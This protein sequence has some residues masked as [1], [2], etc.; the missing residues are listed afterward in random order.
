MLKQCIS[1]RNARISPL[2][3]RFVGMCIDRTLDSSNA[4]SRMLLLPT[5]LFVATAFC[6]P[7][8]ARPH[9][10]GCQR[11]GSFFAMQEIANRVWACTQARAAHFSRQL[12][13][14]VAPLSFWNAHSTRRLA[15][16]TAHLCPWM[17]DCAKP[18]ATC[19]FEVPSSSLVLKQETYFLRN[20]EIYYRGQYKP[21]RSFMLFWHICKFQKEL[22]S[23]LG[24]QCNVK[25]RSHSSGY[26]T[27]LRN[28]RA[29]GEPPTQKKIADTEKRL[30]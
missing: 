27:K 25:S 7:V 22:L 19:S 24:M 23:K 30:D 11:T 20:L 15:C 17:N 3:W 28:G 18:P 10:G 5:Q 14:S 9:E 21:K 2:T 12:S 16:S 13:S 6:L 4:I 26:L 1:L 8:E 29:C